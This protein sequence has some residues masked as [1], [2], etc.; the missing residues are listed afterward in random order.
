[1]LLLTQLLEKLFA[2]KVCQMSYKFFKS[3]LER[4]DDCMIFEGSEWRDV[5]SGE[6]NNYSNVFME[7]EF[8]IN[9]M[10]V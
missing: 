4:H 5:L 10:V 9:M 8:E 7:L 3:Q 2:F 1:M 6:L